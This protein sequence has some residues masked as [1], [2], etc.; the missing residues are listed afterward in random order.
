MKKVGGN[1]VGL[2]DIFKTKKE[3]SLTYAH[4]LSGTT[5]IFSQFGTDIYASDVVQQAINCIV[6]EMKKIRPIHVK[7]IGLDL[8]PVN[9]SHIQR[10]LRRPNPLM[11]TSEFM[12]KI[13][14]NLHLNYNSF[15][16][17][18]FDSKGKLSGLYPLQPIRVD[19][20]ETPMGELFVEMHFRNGSSQV[21]PYSKILHI[22]KN[23]SVNDFMGGN[24]FG[25][26]DNSALLK[27]LDLN[28]TLL[29]GVAKAMK[30]S[31]AVN[32]V[33]KYNTM[34]DRANMP[35]KIKEFEKQ[36]RDSNSGIM[37]MD[38]QAEFVPITRDIQ[39]VDEATLKFIDEKILRHFGV[40]LPILTGDYSKDQYEAF[41]QKTLEPL[42]IGISQVF[43]DGI[44]S[45]GELDHG[46]EIQFFTSEL[47][48]MTMDQKIEMIRLLGDAGE[49]YSNEKRKAFGLVPLMELEGVRMQSLNYVNV[50]IA[51]KYQ[52][53][54]SGG[55]SN[56]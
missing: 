12:E 7:T 4:M 16:Y 31:F 3:N 42:I 17:K 8:V 38:L 52:L 51:N 36:L 15:V 47:I 2:F 26:P 43:T 37:G 48:F 41:Y 56:E 9:P 35:E 30:S 50:E 40:P 44:F 39:L 24:Q 13:I 11:T 20:L 46:N 27:T 5:P 54:D 25:E 23:Y 14:W 33:V 34:V 18:T 1:Q 53:K 19:F 10:V 6:Q 55:G 32:G 28:H 22:R 29:E 21:I 49:L 45:E